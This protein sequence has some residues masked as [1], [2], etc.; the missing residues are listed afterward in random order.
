MAA[1]RT[2]ACSPAFST[3]CALRKG[4]APIPSALMRR[5]YSS[6]PNSWKRRSGL[7]LTA[8][9]SDVREFLQ[10]LF[11][12]QVDGRSV[13]R[14]LSALR[15]LYRYLLLDKRIDMIPRWT[16]NRRG[17]GRFCRR[18]WRAMRWSRRWR[19][20][21]RR[22]WRLGQRRS[23]RC[24]GARG[25]RPG[26]AGGFICGGA[27]GL[28]NGQRYAEDL[29][30]DA[31]YMLVRGK[32]D[33]ERIVPLGRPAQDALGVSGAGAPCL[34]K[35]RSR[36]PTLSLQRTERQGWGTR[37]ANEFAFAVYRAGWAQADA[38]AN[39][40]DGGRC[41][42][43]FGTACIAAHAA[44]FVRHA[45]GGKWRGPAHGADDSG[46]R[47]YFDDTDLHSSGAGSAADRVSEASSEGESEIRAIVDC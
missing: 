46:S 19:L 28:G 17:N 37:M 21:L 13:G 38:A 1:E 7:L 8:R 26:H 12:H 11:S 9:R 32:G 29:K 6:F 20:R 34:R 23:K 45:H 31:G 3:T 36:T 18:R 24:G 41:L 25:S 33:K 4:L 14:K 5:T 22:C 47:R 39:L 10:Q 15:H 30:L 2:R 43:G 27:A 16:L 35:A 44:A 42:G 40:A